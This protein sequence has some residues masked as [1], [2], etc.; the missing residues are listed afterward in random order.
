MGAVLWR[1]GFSFVEI[2]SRNGFILASLKQLTDHKIFSRGSTC[3]AHTSRWTASRRRAWFLILLGFGGYDWDA[4]PGHGGQW[5]I[6]YAEHARACQ[7]V[8]V[9]HSSFRMHCDAAFLREVDLSPDG[10]GPVRYGKE[11]SSK[12]D[13]ELFLP[14]RSLI[15][16]LM[17]LT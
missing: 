3:H 13:A 7:S 16:C 15:A 9:L 4:A 12:D 10:M 2:R 5:L 8:S 11:T 17:A 14:I 1:W 6:G